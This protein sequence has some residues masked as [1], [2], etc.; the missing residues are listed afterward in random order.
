MDLVK[1]NYAYTVYNINC[2]TG[3]L[4]EDMIHISIEN[5]ILIIDNIHVPRMNYHIL[6]KTCIYD[7]DND[8]MYIYTENQLEMHVADL[9]Y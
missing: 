9:A 5:Y 7:I 3:I 6:K 2:K 8:K 1:E 4:I